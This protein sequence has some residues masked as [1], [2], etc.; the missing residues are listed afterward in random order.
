MSNCG[1]PG[2]WWVFIFSFCSLQ[3]NSLYY[4]CHGIWSFI[5]QEKEEKAKKNTEFFLFFSVML[6]S[7]WEFSFVLLQQQLVHDVISHIAILEMHHLKGSRLGFWNSPFI[8]WLVSLCCFFSLSLLYSHIH[9]LL[10]KPR[11]FAVLILFLCVCVCFPL[12]HSHSP[13]AAY[14]PKA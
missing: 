7:H 9:R 3:K 10:Q 14:A 4:V 12:P 8:L 2:G 1:L 5:R 6:I 13:L 11:F